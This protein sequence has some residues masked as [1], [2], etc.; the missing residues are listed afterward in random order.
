MSHFIVGVT[1]GIGSGK[2]T[3]TD[4]FAEKGIAVVDA[5]EI[6][7]QVVAKGSEGLAKI[8]AHFGDDV[9]Q[10]NG[11]LDRSALRH[12]VFASSD[13]KKWLDALLHPLIREQMLTQTQQANSAYAILSIPLLIENKLQPMVDRV[14]VVDL[15]EETQL[16]RAT[17]RDNADKESQAQTEQT[18]KAIIKNQCSRQQRLEVADD[19]VNNNSD[20]LALVEQVDKLHSQYLKMAKHH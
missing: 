12:R 8:A 14:L 1:G 4:L 15:D 20:L 9:I 13:D 17:N 5:D 19:V 6:A 18:I 11:E 7:R 3:V 16:A 2:T 10:E